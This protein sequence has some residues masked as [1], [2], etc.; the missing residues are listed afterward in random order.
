MPFMEYKCSNGHVT[1]RFFKN[2]RT[3]EECH[4]IECEQC[5]QRADKIFS[6][7]LGFGLYGDPAGYEKPSVTK[8]F[9]TKTVSK[10]EG[11]SAAI[12]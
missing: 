2:I 11:N 4:Y 1:E 9:S 10:K 5:G 3:A 6:V 12:G 7:P 8:R